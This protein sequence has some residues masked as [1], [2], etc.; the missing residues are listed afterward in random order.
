MTIPPSGAGS[1]SIR[2][3]TRSIG[4]IAV[5]AIVFV[6]AAVVGAYLD[7]LWWPVAYGLGFLL[8]LAALAILVVGGLLALVGRGVV[9][10]IA[11]VVLAVG[12]GILAGQVLGPSREP[13]I[14][15]GGGTMTVSLTSPVVATATGTADCQNVASATEFQVTGD[16][17]M[18]L[19]TPEQPFVSVDLNVGDRWRV[20]RDVPRKD[21]L[22]LDI[23]ITGALVTDAGKPST[24]GMQAA[25]SSV[26]ESTLSNAGGSIRFAGL[27]ARNGPDFSGESIDLAGTIVWTCGAARP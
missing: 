13:L 19:D 24:V 25:E 5:V 4:L 3:T 16:P 27:V 14:D 20:L 6:G 8:A 15:Q 7:W 1:A 17:N 10:R 11:L 18:R 26:V 2:S 12:V 9:R 22:L 21:G 23:G